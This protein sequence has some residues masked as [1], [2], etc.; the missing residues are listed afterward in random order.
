VDMWGAAGVVA[1][2]LVWEFL[3]NSWFIP[4]HTLK[5]I[6]E[7]VRDFAKVIG[8]AIPMVALQLLAGWMLYKVSVYTIVNVVSV[9]LAVSIVGLLYTFYI[10]I[11]EEEEGLLRKYFPIPEWL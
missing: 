6:K 5:L 1:G 3:L 7:K 10:W 11:N 2:F 8:L 4:Y 9:G